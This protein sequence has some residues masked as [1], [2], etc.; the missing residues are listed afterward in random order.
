MANDVA[1]R[2]ALFALVARHDDAGGTV[3]NARRR[4]G[5][6]EVRTEVRG[7]ERDVRDARGGRGE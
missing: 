4:D 1:A 5:L 6:R 2:V 3:R 7:I